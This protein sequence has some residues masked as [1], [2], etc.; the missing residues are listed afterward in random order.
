MPKYYVRDGVERCI[1]IA[2][3][4]TMA[5]VFALETY[6]FSSAM[7]NGYYWVSERGFE[8]HPDEGDWKINSNEVNKIFLALTQKKSENSDEDA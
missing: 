8:I 1:I 2:P 4:P 3:T 5:C 6:K 7:V